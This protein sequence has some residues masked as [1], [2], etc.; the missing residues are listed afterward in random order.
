MLTPEHQTMATSKTRIHTDRPNP[1]RERRR[2]RLR[3]APR[4]VTALRP[5]LFG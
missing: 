5:T 2:R 1:A 3:R 4:I